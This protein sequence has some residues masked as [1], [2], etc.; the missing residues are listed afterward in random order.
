M[1]WFGLTH[2]VY[3]ASISSTVLAEYQRY[4]KESLRR[5][6]KN[7]LSTDWL[8]HDQAKTFPL[9]GYYVNLDLLK[10]IKKATEDEPISLGRIHDLFKQL[11]MQPQ[12][13]NVLIIGNIH[14]SSISDFRIPVLK[15]QIIYHSLLQGILDQERAA[16]L[17]CWP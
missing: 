11:E 10:K 2:Y 4:N 16:L 17:Q 6:L 13:I 15:L 14:F 12:A 8:P 9:R 1:T 7:Y 3:F 5:R